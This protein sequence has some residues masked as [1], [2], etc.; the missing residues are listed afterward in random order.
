MGWVR[1]VYSP[2]KCGSKSSSRCL[3]AASM[4]SHG[5]LCNLGMAGAASYWGMDVTADRKCR[6]PD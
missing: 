1:G 2:L 4:A 3:S 5:L 6:A